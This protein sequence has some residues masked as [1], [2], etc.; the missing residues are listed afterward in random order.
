M[1]QARS[2][3]AAAPGVRF[4]A[5]TAA[6][7]PSEELRSRASDNIARVMERRIPGWTRW[8]ATVAQPR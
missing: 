7:L 2:I 1:L 5:A 3:A 6:A 4:T 8:R